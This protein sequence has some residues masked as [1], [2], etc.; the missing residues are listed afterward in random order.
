MGNPSLRVVRSTACPAAL[1]P[2]SASEAAPCT[3]CDTAVCALVPPRT[4]AL[5]AESTAA[6]TAAAAVA[7]DGRLV[8]PDLGAHRIHADGLELYRE[9]TACLAPMLHRLSMGGAAPAGAGG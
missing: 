3:T 4:T 9:A 7:R 6:G 2:R 5:A 8:E 1:N